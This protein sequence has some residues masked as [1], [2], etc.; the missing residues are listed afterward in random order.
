VEASTKTLPHDAALPSHTKP[1]G[2]RGLAVY[3]IEPSRGIGW[4]SLG[5]L[6][7]YREL[8]YFFLWRDLKVRYKQTMLGVGWAMLQPL[9]TMTIFSVIFGRLA[10]VPTDS[11]PYPVFAFCA[12]VPW[13]LFAFALTESS[14]SVVSN[15]RLLTKVY[16]PRLVMPIA[17]VFVG[18]ADFAISLALLVGLMLFYGIV[19]GPHVVTVP[20]WAGLATGCALGVGLWLSALN[21]RYRDVRYMLPFLTQI[22]M[23]ISPV[24]YSSS[25]IPDKWR[26]LYSLNP[27][28]G[29]IEGFRWSLLGS[30]HL[31]LTS[32]A[33]S[34]VV[35]AVLV[36]TGLIYFR[37]SE[38]GFAD[39]V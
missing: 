30:G 10:R 1:A 26:P 12:L 39:I 6:W 19:P 24:A 4:L 31:D 11:L 5:E 16:F 22:W 34:A 20:I 8:L 23:Y 38:R 9:A 21:V 14:N 7:E 3:L 36:I 33:I 18:L 15:Q 25:L 27:L 35:V 17:A 28:V 32:T 37:R 29:V 2:G 13:Q